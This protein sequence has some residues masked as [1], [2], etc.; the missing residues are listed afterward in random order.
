[1]SQLKVLQQ[2]IAL[3]DQHTVESYVQFNQYKIQLKNDLLKTK[4]QLLYLLII[5]VAFNLIFRASRKE[6]RIF[7]PVNK[8]IMASLFNV[9]LTKIIL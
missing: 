6:S 1:M 2:K 7:T 4:K 9:M 8:K 5:F 3:C